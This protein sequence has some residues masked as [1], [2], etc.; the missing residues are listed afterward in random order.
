L[1]HAFRRRAKIVDAWIVYGWVIVVAH[2]SRWSYQD[3]RYLH[4]L[5]PNQ[6]RRIQQLTITF[7]HLS[8]SNEKHHETPEAKALSERPRGCRNSPRIDAVAHNATKTG[9]Y[10]ALLKIS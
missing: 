9:W 4:V 6:G 1:L 10:T 3:K 2:R 7:I 8:S 5:S